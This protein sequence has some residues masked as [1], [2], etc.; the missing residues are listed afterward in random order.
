MKR[1]AE[2]GFDVQYSQKYAAP[3]LEK[4]V[5]DVKAK[6]EKISGLTRKE[7]PKTR[8]EAASRATRDDD[9]LFA[10]YD[11]SRQRLIDFFGSTLNT[12]KGVEDKNKAI[13][14]I[15]N[16]VSREQRE[17]GYETPEAAPAAEPAP[18]A[19]Q[20][21]PP[22]E[23]AAPMESESMLQALSEAPPVQP[24][25]TAPRTADVEAAYKEIEAGNVPKAIPVDEE[26]LEP[27]K[28]QVDEGRLKSLFKTS[29]GT[30]F[31]PKSKADAGRMAQLRSFVES[32]P[33]VLNKS[34]V[35]ASL[36]F[37]RTLK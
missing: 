2:S 33:E 31:N 28:P 22:T 9:R 29:T 27:T 6:Q 30:T 8:A 26:T 20:P 32:N 21:A 35:G 5:S 34:D 4:L 25:E 10:D 16:Q 18:K 24:A 15:V 19:T 36:A 1:S 7:K 13:T 37:Y 12:P 11:A 3:T 17:A 14:D 23:S